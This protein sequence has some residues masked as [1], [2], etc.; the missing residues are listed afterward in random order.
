MTYYNI[1][2]CTADSQG[3]VYLPHVFLGCFYPN[4]FYHR[5]YM[6]DWH[7]PAVCTYCS[8]TLLLKHDMIRT[9]LYIYIYL[10]TLYFQMKKLLFNVYFKILNWQ[11]LFMIYEILTYVHNICFCRWMS[12]SSEDRCKQ[13]YLGNVWPLHG[14]EREVSV[15]VVCCKV[16]MCT[17]DAPLLTVVLCTRPENPNCSA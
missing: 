10:Y 13:I 6:Y 8:C 5:V 1:Y 4:W 15:D 16:Y 12:P 7:H 3:N 17:T 9:L 11:L 14:F 2:K